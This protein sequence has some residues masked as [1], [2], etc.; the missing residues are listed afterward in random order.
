MT[1]LDD[2]REMLATVNRIR[3]EHGLAKMSMVQGLEPKGI[4]F[5]ILEDKMGM[6]R[7]HSAL[8]TRREAESFLH[9]Q[10]DAF[11]AYR[12]LTESPED[13]A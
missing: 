8:Y 10:V 3:G 6:R 13:L 7:C 9:G 11:L 4:Q 5:V 12:A 1:T 2:V